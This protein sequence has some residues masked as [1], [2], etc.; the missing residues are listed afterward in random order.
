MEIATHLLAA[1]SSPD[2]LAKLTLSAHDNTCPVIC[3]TCL[4]RFSLD[5]EANER[6][7]GGLNRDALVLD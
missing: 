4:S 6:L 2:R 5:I 7:T 1:L 3:D